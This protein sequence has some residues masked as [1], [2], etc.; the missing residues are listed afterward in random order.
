MKSF[1]VV[2]LGLLFCV[3]IVP[4]QKNSYNEVFGYLQKYWGGDY[5]QNFQKYMVRSPDGKRIVYFITKDVMVN[6]YHRTPTTYGL[7]GENNIVVVHDE[8]SPLW[9]AYVVAHEIGHF[10][11][12]PAPTKMGK[13]IEAETDDWLQVSDFLE[14]QF[15]KIWVDHVKEICLNNSIQK[16]VNGRMYREPNLSAIAT[17]KVAL[18][19][20]GVASSPKDEG[21]LESFALILANANQTGVSAILLASNYAF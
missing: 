5:S 3:G 12:G 14:K 8:L 18:A 10:N 20:Q 11:A 4:A 2:L 15:G 19:E 13:K 17:F 1:F 7:C 16:T 21:V 6:H 9:E